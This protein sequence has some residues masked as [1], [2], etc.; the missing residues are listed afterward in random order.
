MKSRLFAALGAVTLCMTLAAP[1]LPV[2]AD[3]NTIVFG[4]P[5]SLTG[6]LTKEGHLTQEGYELLERL[7]QRARR[8]QGRRQDL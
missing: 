2:A 1:S 8:P 7:R 5:V 6:A 4:S 3:A